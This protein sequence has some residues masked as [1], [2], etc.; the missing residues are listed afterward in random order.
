MLHLDLQDTVDEPLL[1]MF[2]NPLPTNVAPRLQDQDTVD[3]PLLPTFFNPL[4]T[5]V[6][7]RPVGHS[8]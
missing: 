3:E 1:A 8:Q 7:P 4:P 5:N 6:A 2:F